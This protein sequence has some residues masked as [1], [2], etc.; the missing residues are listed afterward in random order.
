[1]LKAK[2]RLLRSAMLR[3]PSVMIRYIG[4]RHP[5]RWIRTLWQVNILAS[6]AAVLACAEQPNGAPAAGNAGSVATRSPSGTHCVD[7]GCSIDLIEL[8]TLS[9]DAQP[10]LFGETVFVQRDGKGRYYVSTLGFAQIA[11]FSAAGELI[12]TIGRR[13]S[14]PGE[15][16]LVMAPVPGPGDSMYAYDTRQLKL[17]VIDQSLNIAR[18]VQFQHYPDLSLPSGH[19][20]SARQIRTREQIGYPIHLLSPDGQILRSFGTDTAQYRGDLRLRFSRVVGPGRAGTIWS[21][22]PGRYELEEWDPLE[23]ERPIRRVSV[24]S[25]WFEA[26]DT[27]VLDP[28][29][30]RPRPVVRQLWEDSAG[31][32][33]VLT[34]VA[35]ASWKQQ[36]ERAPSGETRITPDQ[37][38]SLYDWRIDVV[39]PGSGAVLATRRFD[40]QIWSR[41][42]NTVLVSRGESHDDRV[43]FKIWRA[44]LRTKEGS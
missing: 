7:R 30:E 4:R 24:E 6:T 32:V 5:A 33:W 20:I 29:V 23:G 43:A 36:F 13:G 3:A 41:P 44:Q 10:G 31:L 11:V 1:M 34:T 14:G 21:V 12:G 27:P 25:E 26:S 40:E 42:P 15:F 17:A 8:A 16:Q 19:F 9:D 39:H 22:P 38:N 18:E 28:R 2:P 37:S 35:D